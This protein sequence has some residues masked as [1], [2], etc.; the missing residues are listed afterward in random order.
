MFQPGLE[1]DDL[2]EIRS[3]RTD[4]GCGKGTLQSVEAHRVIEIGP[5]ETL[6]L[7]EVLSIHLRES[8]RGADNRIPGLEVGQIEELQERKAVGHGLDAESELLGL[9]HRPLSRSH[10]LQ[11]RGV[12]KPVRSGDRGVLEPPDRVLLLGG[13]RSHQYHSRG[14]G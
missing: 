8:F 3:F 12:G 13:I 4:E 1:S 9:L 14:V 7:G 11:Y 2:G 6:D 10:D 5:G